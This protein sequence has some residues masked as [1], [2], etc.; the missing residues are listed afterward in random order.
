MLFVVCGLLFVVCGL[1][2]VVCCLLVVDCC[3]LFVVC[4]VL[5]VVRLVTPQICCLLPH[6]FEE[7]D[8]GTSRSLTRLPFVPRNTV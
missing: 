8:L 7:T 2:F 5:F 4:C 1:L 3:L 6:R